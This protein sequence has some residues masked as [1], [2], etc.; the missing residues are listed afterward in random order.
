MTIDEQAPGDILQCS[1]CG[2]AYDEGYRQGVEDARKVAI[3]NRIHTGYVYPPLTTISL[4][5]FL[6]DI[7]KLLAGRKETT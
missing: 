3:R 5:G 2:R 4:S 6:E 7:D 1:G